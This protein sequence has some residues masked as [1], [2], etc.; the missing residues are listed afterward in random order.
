MLNIY[1]L[2]FWARE[3]SRDKIPMV[4]ASDGQVVK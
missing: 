3:H 4:L 2:L 1:Q